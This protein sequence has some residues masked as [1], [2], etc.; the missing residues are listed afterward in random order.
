MKPR[1]KVAFFQA[2]Q[3]ISF[4]VRAVVVDKSRVEKR[5]VGMS[6]Q[7]IMV[8]FI[9]HLTLRASD[10]DIANDVMVID[11]ATRVFIRA[12]RLKLSEECRQLG[13]VHP[14][15]KIVRGDSNRDEGLQLADM[16]AGAVRQYAIGVDR[17]HYQTF[18][19][20]VVDLW[21]VPARGK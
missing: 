7:D 19:N 13:R 16:I 10:L 6:G 9:S 18:M 8:E 20:K 5:L 3:T 2:I 12:L 15:K 21:E 11:G 14:F 1:Q 17:D 4:R